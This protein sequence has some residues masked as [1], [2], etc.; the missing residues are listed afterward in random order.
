MPGIN[1]IAWP[2]TPFA[3]GEPPMTFERLT[4]GYRS[5]CRCMG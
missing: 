3:P 4:T 5:A 2:G 1:D